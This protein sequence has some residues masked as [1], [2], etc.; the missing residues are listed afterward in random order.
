MAYQNI[1][2][3][4]NTKL[5][6]I[7]SRNLTF[8]NESNLVNVLCIQTLGTLKKVVQEK[9]FKNNQAEIQFFKTIKVIPM[10][11]LIYYT[12]V[13]SCE[14]RMP[15]IGVSP[16]LEF[17]NKQINKVNTLFGRHTE[18]LLYMEEGYTHFDTHYFTREHLNHI[19]IVKSY[20]YF[21]D[22]VF[23]TSHDETWARIKGLAIFIKYLKHKKEE[24][25]NADRIIKESKISWTGPYSALVELLYACQSM[26]YF[27]NGNTSNN[28]IF[29]LFAD[30][31]NIKKGN[32]S[33]TYSEIK[34]R[35]GSRV[36]FLEEAAQ[37]LLDKMDQEDG[38]HKD[39][40]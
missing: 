33:R 3:D 35:K 32:F 1:L 34:A 22:T 7:Q 25:Q 29:D 4:F 27:N 20:P 12:E 10:K 38:F 18:F 8:L 30:F 9:G 17:L 24:V 6:K 11:Y 13:R 5:K 31:L 40:L 28:H 23:N 37:K 26:G 21:K 2:L 19:P 15:K 16:K 14:L 39:E 36:K